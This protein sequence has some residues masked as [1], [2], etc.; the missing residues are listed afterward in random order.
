MEAATDKRAI[1]V[2]VTWTPKE[3]IAGGDITK[4]ITIDPDD[5]QPGDKV[6]WSVEYDES[7]VPNLARVNSASQPKTAEALQGESER[8]KSEVN[9]EESP[10]S[11]PLAQPKKGKKRKKWKKATI[12]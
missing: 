4:D 11:E 6:K 9:S 12:L 5:L 1:C 10:P 8:R 2:E 7:G 3:G